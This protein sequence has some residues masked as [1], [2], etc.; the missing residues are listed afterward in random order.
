[1]QMRDLGIICASVDCA[2]GVRPV[3]PWSGSRR[4]TPMREAVID[5]HHRRGHVPAATPGDWVHISRRRAAR[6]E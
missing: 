3:H 4:K 1:M 5:L 6:A 2:H